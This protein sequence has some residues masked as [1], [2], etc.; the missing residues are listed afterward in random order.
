MTETAVT[1]TAV[2][3][4]AVPEAAVTG[5]AVPKAEV[6]KAAVPRTAVPGFLAP[7]L[8]GATYARLLHLLVGWIFMGVILLIYP[9]TYGLTL[10][11]LVAE[12]AAVD[13][14][15]LVLV[16]LI[17]AARRAE[18]VQAR[19][20]LV[21]D[22][23]QDIAV[24]PSG[25]WADRW[26]TAL[27]LIGR[28]VLGSAV[29]MATVLCINGG[30]GLLAG[31]QGLNCLLLLPV[32]LLGYGWLV[33]GAGRLQL[34]MAVRLLGPS[35]AERL[36]E[37]E[38]RAERL[39]ERNRLARELHDS[40]GHAL[41]VTVIQAGAAR[42]VGDPAFVARALEVIEETGRQAMEDLERTLVL[43]RE[44][45]E[46]ATTEH[47]GVDQLPALFETVRAAGSPVEARVDLPAGKLP[48][49]LSRESYRIVQEGVTNA[50]KYAP[51]E[52]V[53]VRIA[54]QDGQLELRCANALSVGGTTAARHPG[55]GARKGGKGLRGIR[56]RATL[57]G[58]EAT[59]G[60][61]QDGSG[62]WVLAVRLPLRLGS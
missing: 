23:E 26:R 35:P 17:P 13:S 40:I 31:P 21:P 51:G 6:P 41:T 25:G 58:G 1:K 60:P 15:L 33:V 50:L 55:A 56:E 34:A 52:P 12:A 45:P 61:A 62:E 14:A 30:S 57:L 53:S 2:T 19:L 8:A 5:A 24:D 29:G 10:G 32:A 46:G 38:L 27:W 48:G 7:L 42:E 18:G 37:A 4:A 59:A 22:R 20:L 11:R 3:K 36:A 47:P 49:V 44:A 39:L 43:L 16:A 28:V 9:G 54:V